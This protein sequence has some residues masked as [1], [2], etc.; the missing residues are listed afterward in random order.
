ML[1]GAAVA[2][3]VVATLAAVAGGWPSRQTSTVALP[4][5]YFL[6]F[7]SRSFFQRSPSLSWYLGRA[8][9]KRLRAV[10]LPGRKRCCIDRARVATGLRAPV[11]GPYDRRRS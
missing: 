10:R 6:A 3:A 1:I 5:P 7:W 8:C 11:L 9:P 4:Q 2:F